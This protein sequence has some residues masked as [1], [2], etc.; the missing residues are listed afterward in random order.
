MSVADAAKQKEIG[1]TSRKKDE[2]AVWSIV[3]VW[4]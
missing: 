1:F 4:P 3:N 2:W